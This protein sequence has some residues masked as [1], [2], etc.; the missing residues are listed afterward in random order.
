LSGT[1]LLIRSF[2]HVQ[3][4]E[5]G[6]RPERV[7]TMRLA[8]PGSREAAL[9]IYPQ[10]LERIRAL[11]GV[12]QVGMV[13]DVLQRRNPDYAIVAEGR[14]REPNAPL[15]GDAVSAD[16][17]QA[18]GCRLIRGRVFSDQ[19]R[20]DSPPV[21]VVNEAMAR[22]F[23]PGEDPIGKRF[24]AADSERDGPWTTVVGV[25]A[26]MRRQ[27]LE[28]QPIAQVFWPHT[29][30]PVSSMDVVVRTTVD[31]AG[32]ASASREQIRAIDRRVPVFQMATL[33]KLLDESL[34]T[35]RFQSFLLALLSTIALTL[36][37]TGIYGLMHYAVMQRTHELGVRMALGAR[38]SDILRMIIGEGASLAVAGVVVGMVMSVWVTQAL[39]S[40]LVG[41]TAHDPL[42]M[43]VVP[44]IM[45]AAAVV[46]C[47]VPARRAMRIDPLVALRDE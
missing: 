2:L 16:F 25:V 27:G 4:A 22:R 3:A 9:T 23:W 47:C 15:S 35:R 34:S 38:G 10:V 43:A 33:E 39:G 5:P 6:F 28:R 44:S 24:R 31:P 36:A 14:S 29:Q 37:A 18:I 8:V 13:E 40:L 30:R 45:A 21:A 41:V 26:D 32:L 17:F 46:V 1:G 7:L 20:S 19:D 42:T 11:P 12:T